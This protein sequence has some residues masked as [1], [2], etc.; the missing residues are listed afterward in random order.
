VRSL[1]NIKVLKQ[2]FVFLLVSIL[3]LRLEAQE[4]TYFNKRI[5]HYNNKDNA[6]NIIEADSGYIIAGYT[7][8][9]DPYYEYD[10]KLTFTGLTYQGEDN[11]FKEYGYDSINIFLGQPGSL[12]RYS[13]DRYISVG[14][15]RIFTESF[16]DSR[17]MLACYNS[18]FDTLWTRLYGEKTL[19]HDTAFML[20]QVKKT[21]DNGF[22]MTGH[23]NPGSSKFH[24]WLL[25]TDSL[26]NLQWET[27]IGDG[28]KYYSGYSVVQ[29]QDGGFVIG[30]YNFKIGVNGMGDPLII[31]TDSLGNEEWRINPGNP[32]ID[33]NKVMVALAADGNIIAGTNYGT[34]ESGDNQWM[35]VKI[36][37]ITPNGE[38]LW[39]YNY[40]EPGYDKFLA[41]TI[42]L[43]NGNIITNGGETIFDSGPDRISWILC[44]DSLGNQLWYKEYA[45]LQGDYSNNRLYD[46]KETS[47]GGLIGCGM[48][49]PII[50][51]TGTTDIWVMKMDSLGCVEAGCD[52]TVDVV[53]FFESLGSGFSIYPN[54]VG[55][56][57]TVAFVNEHP[58]TYT[59]QIY[60]MYGTKVKEKI[61]PAGKFSIRVSSSTWPGGVYVAVLS[62]KGSPAVSLKFLVQRY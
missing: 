9:P 35:V 16:V 47:D 42:V 40:G 14:T 24:I 30:G 32:D 37:K 51:D 31:K 13:E 36:M 43:D 59:L 48:V 57:F 25:K 45:L 18:S 62:S 27:F 33:D 54:P 56:V 60:D 26:G 6:R 17:G 49:S 53:E 4:F 41:N 46:V 10:I 22:I 11:L 29:T 20:D 28:I 15:W 44:T 21:T 8:D 23:R 34:Q 61:I 50:P 3:F 55:E 58:Q 5:D 39:D 2:V 12:I 7:Y 1:L 19:P 38:V 52:T